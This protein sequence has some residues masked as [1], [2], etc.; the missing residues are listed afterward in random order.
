MKMNTVFWISNTDFYRK[1]GL[2]LGYS[3]LSLGENLYSSTRI[4][5]NKFNTNVK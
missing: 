1:M 2:L 4:V 5:M 3:V